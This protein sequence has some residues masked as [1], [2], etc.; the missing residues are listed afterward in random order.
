VIGRATA[1]LLVLIAAAL[2]RRLGGE[3]G[4]SGTAFALGFAL[5]AA[6]LAGGIFERIRLPRITG[7]LVFG[8]VCGPYLANVVDR[9]MAR[10]LQFVNGLAIALIAFMAGL[11][12]NFRH[13]APRMTAMLRL[14]TAMLAVC[15]IGVFV[16]IWIAW[17]WLPID[18]Q[19]AGLTRVLRR[20]CWPRS[21][22]RSR[23]P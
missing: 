12:L 18:P 22:S 4:G 9:T 17:P 11:E 23:P 13:L 16:C 10:D 19:S 1:L 2:A 21:W 8:M 3:A 20:A 6:A 7:Y 5:I 15:Y 14:G